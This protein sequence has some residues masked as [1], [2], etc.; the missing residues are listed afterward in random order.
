MRRKLLVLFW[1]GRREHSFFKFRIEG[2]IRIIFEV[3]AVGS[4]KFHFT[5]YQTDQGSSGPELF[6]VADHLSQK[7]D[8]I[9][10]GSCCVFG[11][12]FKRPFTDRG[13]ILCRNRESLSRVEE[14]TSYMLIFHHEAATLTQKKIAGLGLL[15]LVQPLYFPDLTLSDCSP[16]WSMKY[17][18]NCY[19]PQVL[20]W[21]SSRTYFSS[22]PS[23][24]P[25][26]DKRK[27]KRAQL[28][29][30]FCGVK[31]GG[32]QWKGWISFSCQ[33]HVLALQKQSFVHRITDNF[34]P[35]KQFYSGRP[36]IEVLLNQIPKYNGF[37]R[38]KCKSMLGWCA[39]FTRKSNYWRILNCLTFTWIVIDSN[40]CEDDRR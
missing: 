9:L 1:N 27:P 3:T 28:I 7:Q 15:Q 32:S 33:T 19:A 31:H 13:S 4:I 29:V 21:K 36:I 38:T 18:C 6:S 30:S 11:E 5:Y 20:F 35:G 40:N 34:M 24:I 16:P 25:I 37:H 17:S 10:I 2:Q 22:L 26:N 39:F 23:Y 12:I 8:L 14:K